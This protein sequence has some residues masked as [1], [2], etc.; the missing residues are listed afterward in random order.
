MSST[1]RDRASRPAPALL[2]TLLAILLALATVSPVAAQDGPTP[3]PGLTMEPGMPGEPGG[4]PQ[5]PGEA[6]E[7]PFDDGATPATPED[8]LLDVID[9][10]WDHITVAPDGR[11]LTVYYW[12]GAEGCYG[13]AGVVV[14]V[15]GEVPVITIQ[16]GTRPGVE[17]CVALA[18]LYS[19][20]VVLDEPIIG[21]G[22]Q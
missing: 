5:E 9:T 1:P 7:A 22:V 19:T 11:T 20:Q 2:L 12:S 14:D 4:E 3:D 8:G 10:P 15:T 13:L 6:P 21:G 18:Q 17:V 16:T